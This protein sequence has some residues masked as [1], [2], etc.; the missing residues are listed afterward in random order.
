MKLHAFLAVEWAGVAIALTFLLMR[1]AIRWKIFKRLALDDYLVILA[2]CTL[3][4]AEI[5]WHTQIRS[6]FDKT[7]SM[8]PASVYVDHYVSNKIKEGPMWHATYHV[9]FGVCLWSVKFSFLAF[10]WN[11]VDRTHTRG[12]W[13]WVVTSITAITFVTFV[14]LWPWE[15]TG[16]SVE[17]LLVYCQTKPQIHIADTMFQVNTAFDFITD[18]LII[19]I[20]TRILWPARISL[21]KKTLLLAVFA[22]IILTMAISLMRIIIAPSHKLSQTT[23]LPWHWHF[24]WSV[25]EMSLSISVACLISFH[26]LYVSSHGQSMDSSRTSSKSSLRRRLRSTFPMLAS[27]RSGET[28]GADEVGRSE[29]TLVPLQGVYVRNEVEVER[30]EGVEE[31]FTAVPRGYPPK[32]GARASVIAREYEGP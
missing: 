24:T 9:L 3:L 14:C 26:Q 5:I 13:W 20:A 17:H 23:D 31:R 6:Y 2:W 21:L 27:W 19:S 29:T 30:S 32:T 10:F 4:P 8:P 25:V 18:G 11:I 1:L 12:I 7:D 28:M 15:C 16:G 22:C